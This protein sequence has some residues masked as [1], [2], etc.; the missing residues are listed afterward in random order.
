[1]PQWCPGTQLAPDLHSTVNLYIAR[2]M[3]G[4]NFS[5]CHGTAPVWLA[6]SAAWRRYSD[7][8]ICSTLQIG[9]IPK[10]S[11]M[12]ADERSQDLM[13]RSS[14]AWAKKN[15]GQLEDL[16]DPAQLIDI[17]LQTLDSLVVKP[18]RT[19][20][21]TCASLIQPSSVCAAQPI[22]GAI[23]CTGLSTAMDIP[24]GDLAPCA[25][26]AHE[27]RERTYW[28]DSWLHHLKSKAFTNPV[29]S[30]SAEQ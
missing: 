5:T 26:R 22:L 10:V 25:R 1:M 30:V 16:V 18:S 17:P 27:L 9:S 28:T 19:P 13:R 12:L 21:S 15:A 11:P 8:A 29:D 20:E 4:N 7:G 2:C 14:S 24:R 23:D 3:A 6:S